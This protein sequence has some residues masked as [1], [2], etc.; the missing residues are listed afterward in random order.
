MVLRSWEFIK[1]W[2]DTI[3][4]SDE[5]ELTIINAEA[6]GFEELGVYKILDGHDSWGPMAL[7]EGRLLARDSKT[8]KCLD[9]R[10][11]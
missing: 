5:G 2:M 9:I 4:G 3:H 6:N 1:F 8:L 11:K 10:A 7:V